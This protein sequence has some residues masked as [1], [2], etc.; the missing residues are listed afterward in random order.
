MVFQ[1]F[2]LIQQRTAL[3]NVEL[4]LFFAPVNRSERRKIAREILE[5]LGMGER[6]THKPADLSGGEQQRV[7]LA[8]AVVKKPEL[9][10]CDE[11]TG[12]LDQENADIII[13]LLKEL[14]G[15]GLTIVL[16]SHDIE[17]AKRCARKTIKLRYGKQSDNGLTMNSGRISQ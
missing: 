14:N 4:A 16:V 10:F 7:A 3:E 11:P 1:S 17:L 13:K 5:R 6:L 8:R 9:L 12:N 2:N 15:E